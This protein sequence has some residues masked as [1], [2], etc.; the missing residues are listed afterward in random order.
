MG[1]ADDETLDNSPVDRGRPQA[2]TLVAP[3][4]GPPL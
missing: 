3:N 1:Q 4:V 2:G